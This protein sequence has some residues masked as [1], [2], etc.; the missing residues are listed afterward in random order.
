MSVDWLL[1]DRNIS[2]R[3]LAAPQ[4]A[5]EAYGLTL[6][7]RSRYLYAKEDRLTIV[8]MFHTTRE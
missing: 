2:Q 1:V 4:S 5:D 3:V 6:E 8:A 7:D